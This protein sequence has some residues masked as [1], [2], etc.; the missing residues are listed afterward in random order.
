[1]LI[2]ALGFASLCLSEYSDGDGDGDAYLDIVSEL[3]G[4]PQTPLSDSVVF[5]KGFKSVIFLPL[6]LL[7]HLSVQRL[8]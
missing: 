4:S 5:Y 8:V 3:G 1:M 2:T 6:H 7:V